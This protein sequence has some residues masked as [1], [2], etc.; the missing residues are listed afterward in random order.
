MGFASR[1][2]IE[3]LSSVDANGHNDCGLIHEMSRRL[4]A[5]RQYDQYFC[6]ADWRPC[7]APGGS[8]AH[9]KPHPY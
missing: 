6:E 1:N 9:A 7:R 2:E 3:Y 4:D 8:D 5:L